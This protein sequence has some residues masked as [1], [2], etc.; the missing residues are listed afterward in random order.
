M[1][2]KKIK[3]NSTHSESDLDREN[4]TGKLQL[5][6]GS[7]PNNILDEDKWVF[8]DQTSNN[9]T[10]ITLDFRIFDSEY[11]HFF[12]EVEVNTQS[13][14]ITPKILAKLVFIFHSE[15]KTSVHKFKN[16]QSNEHGLETIEYALMVAIVAIAIISGG[17]LMGNAANTK[18]T[19]TAS[20]ISS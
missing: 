2:S 12:D 9:D 16:F 20:I 15:G 17:T 13:M 19:D 3:I 11:F 1:R 5:L 6:I 10:K 4:L 14:I 18:F 8:I 7:G